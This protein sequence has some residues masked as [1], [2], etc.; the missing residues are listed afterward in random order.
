[1]AVQGD[2]SWLD[3]VEAV[4]SACAGYASRTSSTSWRA[5]RFHVVEWDTN[6]ARDISNVLSPA[7][8]QAV[9][10]TKAVRSRPPLLIVPDRQ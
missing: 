7:K 6:L 3:A 2:Y 4:A 10:S 1:M 8:V 5:K 9:L